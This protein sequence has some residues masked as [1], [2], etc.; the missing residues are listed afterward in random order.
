MGI[1]KKKKK[2]KPDRQTDWASK[3]LITMGQLFPG[4]AICYTFHKVGVIYPRTGHFTKE[5]V[6]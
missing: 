5:Y 1:G 3:L 6:K 4:R 2:K